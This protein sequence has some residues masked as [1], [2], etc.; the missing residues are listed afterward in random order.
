MY[1]LFYAVTKKAEKLFP[2][3]PNMAELSYSYTSRSKRLVDRFALIK[4]NLI[5]ELFY[6]NST[7]HKKLYNYNTTTKD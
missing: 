3:T 1:F 7:I 6:L 2:H 5:C 4:G